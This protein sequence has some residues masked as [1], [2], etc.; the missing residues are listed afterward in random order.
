MVTEYDTSTNTFKSYVISDVIP[1][2]TIP[3]P[4]KWISIYSKSSWFTLPYTSI[5]IPSSSKAVSYVLSRMTSYAIDVRIY[6]QDSATG[7]YVYNTKNVVKANDKLTST[8]PS[9]AMDP[10][11]MYYD[12]NSSANFTFDSNLETHSG[13]KKIHTG[14]AFGRKPLTTGPDVEK[15]T[16][17]FASFPGAVIQNAGV[18]LLAVEGVV[19]D[20]E[21]L[22]SEPKYIFTLVGD[23]VE[24]KRKFLPDIRIRW[25]T[26][27]YVSIKKSFKIK[28]QASYDPITV[29]YRTSWAKNVDLRRVSRSLSLKW[30]KEHSRVKKDLY[31]FRTSIALPEDEVK[32]QFYG[33][34][35]SIQDTDIHKLSYRLNWEKTLHKTNTLKY[36]V[37]WDRMPNDGCIVKCYYLSLYKEDGT[38]IDAVS[39]Q[40]YVD[41]DFVIK[42]NLSFYFSNP[43][44][45]GVIRFAVDRAPYNN[46]FLS[47]HP[48]K[49]LLIDRTD[50][51]S[52]FILIGNYTIEGIDI[53]GSVSLDVVSGLQ[54]LNEYK[55]Y[56]VPYNLDAYQ[57]QMITLNDSKSKALLLNDKF[58]DDYNKD[59]VELDLVILTGTQCC[60]TQKASG[61]RCSPF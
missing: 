1:G 22:F 11:V 9:S 40:V 30:D 36:S 23:L 28:W 46:I 13:N 42:D 2:V 29:R 37:R 17:M 10:S 15:P 26:D 35:W 44:K 54:Q 38:Y 52:N 25:E 6:K 43:D 57:D 3:G 47:E 53:R 39:Y 31:T 61:S 60:F 27:Y 56:W 18:T 50:V 19:K 51:P 41:P 12:L 49:D 55:S 32:R 58:K 8:L 5:L 21:K 33:F 4:N 16:D 59:S 45:F 24:R 20:S 48:D 7:L 14:V 34:N